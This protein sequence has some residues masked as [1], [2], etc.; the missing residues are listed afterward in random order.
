MVY[1]PTPEDEIKIAIKQLELKVANA[2][3]QGD[4]AKADMLSLQLPTL[5]SKS[6]KNIDPNK[7]NYW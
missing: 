4:D 7:K 2:R 6:P 5:K 3:K 1:A